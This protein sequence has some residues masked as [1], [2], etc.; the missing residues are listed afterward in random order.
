MA[1]GGIDDALKNGGKIVE[2]HQHS[3]DDK[4]TVHVMEG[5]GLKAFTNVK[6][7]QIDELLK[8]HPLTKVAPTRQSGNIDNIIKEGGT[9]T[10]AYSHG[11]GNDNYNVHVMRNDAT[12]MIFTNITPERFE[13]LQ[14]LHCAQDLQG[15]ER[16]ALESEANEMSNNRQPH[17]RFIDLMKKEGGEISDYHLTERG[18]YSVHVQT[19]DGKKHAYSSISE[20]H[21]KE[22]VPDFEPGSSMTAEE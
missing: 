10:D 1:R 20:A 6:K 8:A 18:T 11:G 3:D 21:M 14:K 16:S 9:I 13:Q 17:T 7:Q 22:F 15:N 12:E 4:Y 5:E 2:Y 19:K